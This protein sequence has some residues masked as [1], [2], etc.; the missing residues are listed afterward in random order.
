M[1]VVITSIYFKLW[2]FVLYIHYSI[3]LRFMVN[4]IPVSN[5]NVCSLQYKVEVYG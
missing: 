1:E 4:P 2:P 3:R 5:Y